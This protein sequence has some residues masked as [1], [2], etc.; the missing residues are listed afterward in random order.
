ML[1]MSKKDGGSR[2]FYSGKAW[3]PPKKEEPSLR[4]LLR[5]QGFLL[6]PVSGLMLVNVAFL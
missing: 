1:P 6:E 4:G 5:K 3:S 2:P